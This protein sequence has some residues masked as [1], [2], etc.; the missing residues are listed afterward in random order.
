MML[1]TISSASSKPSALSFSIRAFLFLISLAI[2]G[3]QT[4]GLGFFKVKP[5]KAVPTLIFSARIKARSRW[6][7]KF[8]RMSSTAFSDPI[9]RL[10]KLPRTPKPLL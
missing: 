7:I 2:T 8:P 3:I 4:P 6:A 5:N 9:A 10:A 1:L